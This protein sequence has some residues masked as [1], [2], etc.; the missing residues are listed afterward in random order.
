MQ[1]YSIKC[2]SDLQL[3]YGDLYTR[4]VSKLGF[5]RLKWATMSK[6]LVND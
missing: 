6:N 1:S 3:N 4:F 5:I 2:Y